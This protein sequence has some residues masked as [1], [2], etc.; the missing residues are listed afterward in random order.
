[1]SETQRC[2]VTRPYFY[3]SR[4]LWTDWVHGVS[5]VTTHWHKIADWMVEIVKPSVLVLLSIRKNEI[6]PSGKPSS[7]WGVGQLCRH[8][9]GQAS[10][11]PHQIRAFPDVAVRRQHVEN[12]Y[13]RM[14]GMH[15]AAG[16]EYPHLPLS[17]LSPVECV[18]VCV[19]VWCPHSHPYN[20]TPL[21]THAH[22]Q[23]RNVTTCRQNYILW[24]LW[25]VYTH[26]TFAL[27]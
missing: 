14:E 7:L 23:G 5:S 10:R 3:R 24:Y 6:C 1:M 4:E 18:C 12:K 13:S 9:A 19:C 27:F 20:P 11:W 15:V 2:S 26:F 16:T 25:W 21:P 17:V 8:W 22:F